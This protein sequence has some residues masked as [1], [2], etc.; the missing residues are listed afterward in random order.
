MITCPPSHLDGAA[1]I[2]YAV[3]E[4]IPFGKLSSKEKT[5]DI[6]AMAIARYTG[7]GKVYLFLCDAGWNVMQDEEF[8]DADDA[9]K[10]IPQQY[11]G[12]EIKWQYI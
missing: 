11:L 3:S 10:G 8:A 4:T 1:V 2:C 5:L 7:D 9:M 6:H 12:Q